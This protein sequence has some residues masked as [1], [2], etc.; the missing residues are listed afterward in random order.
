MNATLAAFSLPADSAFLLALADAAIKSVA[1][2][3]VAVAVSLGLRKSSAAARHAVWVGALAGALVLPVLSYAL[4]AWRVPWLPAWQAEASS[5][6]QGAGSGEQINPAT[7]NAQPSTLNAQVAS[8]RSKQGANF[9]TVPM[10]VQPETQN[11]KPET[12][13][14]QPPTINRKPQTFLFWLWLLGAGLVLLPLLAGWWQ[15]ARLTRWGKLLD[16]PEWSALLGETTKVLNLKK[17]VKLLTVAGAVMPFTWGAWRPV[18]I[19]PEAAAGWT[20]QRRRLVLLHEL[21]HVQRLDWLTQ[22]L[23]T[24]ACALYWFNPLAWLAARQLRLEREQACDDLVLRCGEQPRDYAHELLE[25]AA[26]SAR[27]RVLNWVAVPVA[28]H[29]KLEIRLRAILDGTRNRRTLTRAALLGL[30]AVA[31]TVV[32]PMAMLRGAATVDKSAPVII[33]APTSKVEDASTSNTVKGVNP[34]VGVSSTALVVGAPEQPQLIWYSTHGLPKGLP[35]VATLKAAIDAK[36]SSPPSNAFTPNSTAPMGSPSA[37]ALP[38]PDLSPFVINQYSPTPPTGLRP[39]DLSGF[40]WHQSSGTLALPGKNAS[41]TAADSSSTAVPARKAADLAVFNQGL[42]ATPSATASIPSVQFRVKATFLEM[43][44]YYN[45]LGQA[46]PPYPRTAQT[47]DFALNETDLGKLKKMPD[48]KVLSE[49]SVVVDNGAEATLNSNGISE[50]ITERTRSLPG[51]KQVVLKIN[52]QTSDDVRLEY[53]M[54]AAPH[55]SPT[56]AIVKGE[57]TQTGEVLGG[58]VIEYPQAFDFGYVGDAHRRIAVV[59]NFSLVKPTSPADT[60]DKSSSE[61]SA[62]T[63]PDDTKTFDLTKPEEKAA[64]ERLQANRPSGIIYN[65]APQADNASIVEATAVFTP[66]PDNF[67]SATSPTRRA[68][69]LAVFNQGLGGSSSAP[70][71]METRVYPLS[72]AERMHL[73]GPEYSGYAPEYQ[74]PGKPLISTNLPPATPRTDAMLTQFFIKLGVPF[75]D[76]VQVA[77]GDEKM[78]VTNTLQNLDMLEKVLHQYLATAR[79][80]EEV[81][82]FDVPADITPDPKTFNLANFAKTPGVQQL[83]LAPGRVFTFVGGDLRLSMDGGTFQVDDGIFGV[84]GINGAAP[85]NS[86]GLHIQLRA[87]SAPEGI[88]YALNGM[89]IERP[90]EQNKATPEVTYPFAFDGMAQN[91]RPVIINL[92]PAQNG[93]KKIGVVVFTV[94]DPVIPTGTILNTSA[95]IKANADAA[96]RLLDQVER[97]SNGH[98]PEALKTVEAA[99]KLDPTNEYGLYA[100][101]SITNYLKYGIDRTWGGAPVLT[102]SLSRKDWEQRKAQERMIMNKLKFIIIPL[103]DFETPTALDEVVLRLKEDSVRYDPEKRGVIL[104]VKRDASSP[105]MPKIVLKGLV[106]VSLDQLVDLICKQTGYIFQSRD[107]SIGIIGTFFSPP[108]VSPT[109]QSTSPEYKT[110]YE[111]SIEPSGGMVGSTSPAGAAFIH[112]GA[113]TQP[114]AG[115]KEVSVIFERPKMTVQ[116]GNSGTAEAVV[117]GH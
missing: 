51:G 42:A 83:N 71:G 4:P 22:T 62:Y 39:P 96:N 73:L 68:A 70:A 34:I 43:P 18:V 104:N 60:K 92:E 24:L 20:M 65:F 107:S 28:R 49:Y 76:A 44:D 63:K 33:D 2:L 111:K 50:P 93:R 40:V 7:L 67:S 78:V 32:V 109:S 105:P 17:P 94:G 26:Q 47:I 61:T 46:S 9:T 89:F 53:Q 57:M 117:K 54:G 16:G 48:V 113:Y 1:L 69:D 52:Y 12:N 19:F 27:N 98:I 5:M 56:G 88:H 14:A 106:N 114:T 30:L 21:G 100:Q 13:F 25:I 85:P 37:Y 110:V 6:E 103:A 74:G 86:P 90:A 41:A 108:N 97:E 115:G 91:G 87:D 35:D 102:M 23:G 75:P 29:S 84:Q 36:G 55:F 66:Q 10:L 80:Q 59:L 116:V 112:S 101:K 38:K 72:P 77:Y 8:P 79:I 15:A 81:M 99:L 58:N 31:V 95:I 64:L 3:A 11:S 82:V 45:L